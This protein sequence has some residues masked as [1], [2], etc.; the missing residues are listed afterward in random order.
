[1]RLK[2]QATCRMIAET[3]CFPGSKAP[4]QRLPCRHR[5]ISK[6]RGIV[7]LT[8]RQRIVDLTEVHQVCSGVRWAFRTYWLVASQNAF[9]TGTERLG[10]VLSIFHA[11]RIQPVLRI[12]GT[13]NWLPGCRE[14]PST[15]LRMTK[16]GGSG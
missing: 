11:V 14:G 16:G 12:S 13:G 4:K 8:L 9:W 10:I 1:M 6:K 3:A 2:L 5:P 15:A 7:E